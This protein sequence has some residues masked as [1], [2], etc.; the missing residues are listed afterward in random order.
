MVK[1][2]TSNPAQT[3]TF[4]G[5]SSTASG[6][7]LRIEQSKWKTYGA[8]QFGQYLV[9]IGWFNGPPHEYSEYF[10]V[11]EEYNSHCQ[12]DGSIVTEIAVHKSRADLPYLLVCSWGIL[13]KKL[14]TEREHI[15]SI[16][17]DLTDEYEFDKKVTDV[18]VAY[19][20]SKVYNEDGEVI[21]NDDDPGGKAG[22][23]LFLPGSTES[24]PLV[25]VVGGSKTLK[26]TFS[27]ATGKLLLDKKVFGVMRVKYTAEYDIYQLKILPRADGFFD[28][29]DRISAYE[30]KVIAF[31]DGQVVVHD[32]ELPDLNAVT[33]G[34]AYSSNSTTV[35]G[36]DIN[37]FWDTPDFWRPDDP[38][39]D[40]YDPDDPDDDGP[41]GPDPDDPSNPT[42]PDDPDNPDDPTDPDDDTKTIN[43]EIDMCDGS[44]TT[45]GP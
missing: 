42:N 23:V 43:Y 44:I 32:V 28:T 21:Y 41:A 4:N 11:Q 3:I 24:D 7:S 2:M 22:G 8:S 27:E 9:E 20:E 14:V 25:V 5:T 10:R 15:E 39:G 31:F 34:T 1:A 38:P 35:K 13:S 18:E 30:S 17:W 29:N 36:G 33:C 26:P 16:T 45:S 19:W 12:S 40:D 37:N 6:D